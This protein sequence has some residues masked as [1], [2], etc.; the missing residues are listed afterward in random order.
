MDRIIADNYK[1]VIW[2]KHVIQKDI[3]D[4]I[5]ND[6]DVMNII[7][8]NTYRGLTAKTKLLEFKL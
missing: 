6:I 5:L 7:E 4:M 2:P 1:I 3:N 8:N